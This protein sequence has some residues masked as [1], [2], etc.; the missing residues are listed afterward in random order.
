[1][2]EYP[3]TVTT[4]DGLMMY[5]KSSLDHIAA[6]DANPGLFMQKPIPEEEVIPPKTL[7]ELMRE[8][9]PMAISM[10]KS[11]KPPERK[12]GRPPRRQE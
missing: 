4:N 2:S 6:Y 5:F 3:K 8:S 1:M 11:Y 7:D 12:R 9:Q 10:E